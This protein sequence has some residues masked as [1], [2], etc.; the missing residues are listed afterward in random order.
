M[1]GRIGECIGVE[2]GTAKAQQC[3]HPPRIRGFRV[4]FVELGQCALEQ[5]A[6]TLEET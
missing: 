4:G 3:I 2:L 5:F 6:R 1:R